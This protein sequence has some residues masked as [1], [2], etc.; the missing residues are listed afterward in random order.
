MISIW[1]IF[2]FLKQK[3]APVYRYDSVAFSEQNTKVDMYIQSWL[4]K[5]PEYIPV[6]VSVCPAHITSVVFGVIIFKYEIKD[7][8][9]G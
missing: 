7:E 3:K 2:S 6:S 9:R 1:S 5:H 8:K 4:K